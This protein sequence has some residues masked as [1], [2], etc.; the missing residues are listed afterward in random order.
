MSENYADE[1]P[2]ARS[3]AQK[4]NMKKI[5]ETVE[6]NQPVSLTKL[7]ELLN[8]PKPSIQRPV[9]RL[10]DFGLLRRE[11]GKDPL[12]RRK[13]SLYLTEKGERILQLIRNSTIE[14]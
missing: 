7:A 2:L 9:D 4:P 1:I 6:R 12:D 10:V 13:I 5:L 11:K 14:N 8:K 3:I